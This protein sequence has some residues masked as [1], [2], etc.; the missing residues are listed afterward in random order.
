MLIAHI[1]KMVYSQKTENT[2]C[3]IYSFWLTLKKTYKLKTKKTIWNR[4]NFCTL[5]HDFF[6][7]RLGKPQKKFF[8]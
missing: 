7:Y 8:S 2:F 3:G 4:N 6:R 1:Y 5:F